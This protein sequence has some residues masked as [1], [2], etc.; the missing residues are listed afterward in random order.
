[1]ADI[2]KYQA[3]RGTAKL[4][5]LQ[6]TTRSLTFKLA[7]TTDPNLYDQPLTLEIMPP[8]TWHAHQL[9]VTDAQ[10]DVV[11]TKRS[12]AAGAAVWR[13]LVLPREAT[14]VVAA[15]P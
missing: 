5:L 6:S 3:E 4:T 2:H 11:P 15:A 13:I 10:G 9:T 8:P 14:Y 7:C 12:K 1:M